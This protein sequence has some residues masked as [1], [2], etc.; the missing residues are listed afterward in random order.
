MVLSCFVVFV[1]T[2]ALI[3]PAI[4][5]DQE[6][7]ER[8]GGIDVTTEQETYVGAEDS[9]VP[10]DSEDSEGAVASEDS[11]PA[12][13]VTSEGKSEQ[14]QA[15]SR[16]EELPSDTENAT[17]TQISTNV[18]T[19]DG[20]DC[21]ITVTYEPEAGIPDGAELSAIEL[22]SD[23]K[24]YKEHYK[25]ALDA[26]EDEQ[27]KS[28]EEDAEKEALAD[29][30]LE[31]VDPQQTV[32]VAF[33]KFF[34]I[35][36]WKDGEELE[37]SAPVQVTIE[38]DDPISV[39]SGAEAEII[40]FAEDGIERI[41]PE[42]DLNGTS[43]AEISTFE[44]QQSS[45]SIS[46]TLVKYTTTIPN[47]NYLI[48]KGAK[49]NGVDRYY[50][51]KA[52]GSTVEVTKNGDTFTNTSSSADDAFWTFTNAG[53][54]RYY[55]Q[56]RS[57]WYNHLVLYNNIV[58]NWNQEIDVEAANGRRAV[59]L[60][61]PNNTPLR[62]NGS[63]Q[64]FVLGVEGGNAEQ[65]FLARM[66]SEVPQGQGYDL[67]PAAE[68]DLGDLLAW[69][70]KIENSKIQVDKSA[71]VFDYDNRIYQ[72]DLK[73]LSDVTIVSNKI[74]LELIV[75]TS[76]S[77]YFPA[78][79][80]AVPSYYFT[81]I[82]GN[83]NHSL[84]RQLS[85][86]SQD[87]VYYF[88]GDGEKATV[89]ALYYAA[90]GTNL[91]DTSGDQCWKFIDAS[92]MNPP[93]AKSMNQS[94]RLNR[95]V[96]MRIDDLNYSLCNQNRPGGGSRIYTAPSS[97]TR[98]AYL[99]EAVRIA[100]EIVYA[101]DRNNRIGLVTFNKEA[102][103]YQNYTNYNNRKQL[104][105][106]IN[107]ISLAGGTRQDLGLQKGLELYNN[108]DPN[109]QKIA[110][111]ITDGAPNM[112]DSNGTQVPSD[113]AWSWIE[114]DANNLKGSNSENVKLYTLGLSMNFVGGNNASHLDG[115]ASDEDGL[116]RHFHAENGPDIA[117][118][119]K[120]LIET[121]VYDA[122]LEA[123]VTD[124]L[125]PAFYPVDRDGNPIAP[126]TYYDENG[127]EYTWEKVT[128]NGTEHWRVTY[129]EQRIGRGEKDSSGNVTSY[130]WTKSFYAKAKED[131][132][133]GNNIK[134]N[135]NVRRYDHVEAKKCVYQDKA[136]GQEKTIDP[137]SN[138]SWGQFSTPYVN[139]DELH[140]P[141]QSTEW[142]VYLG[143]EVNPEEQL[144]LLWDDIGVKQVVKNGGTTSDGSM[145]TGADEMW[146]P[147]GT[148]INEEDKD[149]PSDDAA[150]ARL[151]LSHYP[152]LNGQ[153]EA[154]LAAITNGT[155]YD[156]GNIPYSPYGHNN[157]G[158]LRVTATKTIDSGATDAQANAPEQHKTD[159]TGAP[160]ERYV[161][162]VTYTPS[163]E[164]AANTYPNSAR[165]GKITTGTGEDE[166]KS[167]NEHKI[168]VF[169][170]K[171][172]ILKSDQEHA[173][174]T[175]AEAEF[176]LYRKATDSELNDNTVTKVTPEGLTGS[177][178]LVQT[179]T[180]T[181]G[182]ATT[183]ALPL[184]AD[185]EPYYLVETKSPT[186]YNKLSEPLQIKIDMTGH[187]TWTQKK[188]GSTS[189]TK[190]NPY[191]LSDWLQEA[192]ILVTDSSG[193]ES[194]SAV[195]E[196]PAGQHD[197]YNSNNDTTDASV[198]YRIINSSGVELPN[199]GGPGTTWI[200]L[201]G[202]LLLLGCGVALVTRRRM[203]A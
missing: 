135:S 20:K 202:S 183:D 31:L 150:D 102:Q 128:I 42:T 123:E 125:D 200:Y 12:D 53:N 129:K 190:P 130:G 160:V 78:N 136:T 86:L 21:K 186:G 162:K 38:Y 184:L 79:L 192:T 100:S 203:R 19:S 56:N 10:E 193:N 98:L 167:E 99:K 54:G 14:V 51:L 95:L 4:T 140:L 71:S 37:P 88:I 101:V 115:L 7:A 17:D 6:E 91:N 122:T 174:I 179:L 156:S 137:P 35:S 176:A 143:T 75:D 126:G 133:G 108:S 26:I 2:Y 155:S 83:D 32:S 66:T 13:T 28:D 159:K 24:E 57:N 68:T 194:S 151:A 168:N 64:Q 147:H 90:S 80:E 199:A 148:S 106:K 180:T 81:S 158:Y 142:T 175:G 55:I 97:I 87:Q 197:R 30:G 139:V 41:E 8:Q 34:D 5:L 165:P 105:N 11:A 82:L 65:F 170:K 22:D 60:R 191:V 157:V 161:I 169:V 33:A 119:V 164:G 181:N 40:H 145:M 74:D 171:L 29:L 27:P 89:Y 48:I 23:S 77:M 141:E 153:Y 166:V 111:L 16:S 109:A 50:A 201:I 52:D 61:N 25:K 9:E 18:V 58:G 121:L 84:E 59:Y 198:K 69:K 182:K 85:W 72:I 173:T 63:T 3:L 152:E 67:K 113:T 189:Q 124:A 178:V 154:L 93:D 70:D 46:A 94:D 146:Y 149:A 187:N 110:I 188:D 76:R 118:A 116:T 103:V 185:D 131:F 163:T 127:K 36:I 196:L 96:G 134:T 120:S 15:R 39:D 144:R 107:T 73:A 177:Y 195:Y 104:Y 132:L 49:V 43:D 62:F 172:Q 117:N 138:L 44:Y 47:G 45:F 92:Y 112:Q 1:T 114:S